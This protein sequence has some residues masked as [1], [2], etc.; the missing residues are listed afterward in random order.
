[1]VYEALVVSFVRDMRVDSF[2]IEHESKALAL[3][4]QH[5]LDL[6][7]RYERSATIAQ[8]PL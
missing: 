5:P 3:V 7:S 8:T 2:E 1:M 4:T 6:G